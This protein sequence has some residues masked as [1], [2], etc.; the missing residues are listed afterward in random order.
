MFKVLLFVLSMLLIHSEKVYAEKIV[1][2]AAAG[3]IP[4]SYLENGEQTGILVDV[5]NQAFTR[6]GY[7]VDIKLMPWARCLK[8]AQEGTV[9]GIFSL[10]LTDERQKYLTYTS[11]VL[12]TQI[13]AL[14]VS[15]DSTITYDGDLQ[16]L[17]D[18]S[19][20]II[21]ATSYGPRLD[22]ALEQGLFKTVDEAQSSKSNL[23][24]LLAGRVDLIPSYRHVVFSTAKTLGAAH[25][26]KQLSP[27]IEAIP[28]YLAFTKKRDF[29]IVIREYNKALAAMKQDGS[30][31][32]I[33]EKYLQ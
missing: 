2:A 29:S 24:K 4:T 9:D 15:I 7:T 32:M 17:A 27:P 14:F 8:S 16:Q 10:Y 20:G 25:R 28:S 12:I 23:R 33:F 13:Q 19:I 26:I 3:S 6:A 30:Y 18:N 1:L 11:E 5:I 21:N 31:D 22:A